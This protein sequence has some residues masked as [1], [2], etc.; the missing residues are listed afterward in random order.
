M[1]HT[2]AVSKHR[3]TLALLLDGTYKV[4]R[5]TGDDQVNVLVQVQKVFYVLTLANLSYNIGLQELNMYKKV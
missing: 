5:A 2:L 4:W 1:T 3:D